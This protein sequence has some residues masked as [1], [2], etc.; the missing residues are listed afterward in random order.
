MYMILLLYL[1]C[2]LAD[3]VKTVQEKRKEDLSFDTRL[4]RQTGPADCHMSGIQVKNQPVKYYV[5]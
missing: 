1:L 5:R 2:S 3:I 4:E